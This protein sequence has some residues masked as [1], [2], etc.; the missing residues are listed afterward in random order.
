MFTR[1]RIVVSLMCL[2]AVL[3][4]IGCDSRPQH[5]PNEEAVRSNVQLVLLNLIEWAKQNGGLYPEQLSADLL[6]DV[7]NEAIKNPY[8]GKDAFPVAF[9]SGPDSFGNLCYIPIH[10]GLEVSGYILLGF[11][12][13]P[14]GGEDVDGDGTPDNVV[15]H[16]YSGNI[17]EES[18]MSHLRELQ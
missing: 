16:V 13:D 5:G 17:T 1:K 4:I 15:A 6:K 11:G 12:N 8:S 2:L 7:Q 3:S 18:M 9:G 14:A 10:D